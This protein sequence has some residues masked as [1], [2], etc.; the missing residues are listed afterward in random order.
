[1][2]RSALTRDVT[3]L[4]ARWSTGEALNIVQGWIKKGVGAGGERFWL[5]YPNID[6]IC[7]LL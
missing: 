2:Q 6:V 4:C 7:V 5:V 3:H 1:V